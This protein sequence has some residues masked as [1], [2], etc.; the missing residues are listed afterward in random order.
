MSVIVNA[1]ATQQAAK[2]DSSGSLGCAIIGIGAIVFGLWFASVKTVEFAHGVLYDPEV[3]IQA[4]ME[5]LQ[6]TMNC[7]DGEVLEIRP[8][9][10]HGAKSV[11]CVP[12]DNMPPVR[13][14][15]EGEQR[16]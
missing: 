5:L 13:R 11:R 3:G 2:R 16:G 14:Q 9:G 1:G 6:R 12:G 15:A 7:E 10:E 8:L 4:E